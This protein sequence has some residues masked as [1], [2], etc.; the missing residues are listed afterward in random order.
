MKSNQ[1]S[2]SSRTLSIGN[3]EF[4]RAVAVPFSEEVERIGLHY[5]LSPQ[6][7]EAEP[8]AESAVFAAG[9]DL[10]GLVGVF[11]FVGTWAAT[12]AL[13]ELFDIKLG[14]AIRTAIRNA[15]SK[16]SDKTYGITLA[17][18][19][20][21]KRTTILVVAIGASESGLQK[22]EQAVRATLAF[23]AQKAE[24]EPAE[25]VHMYLIEDGKSD[26]IPKITSDLRSALYELRHMKQTTKPV[27]LKRER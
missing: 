15:F 19:N 18:H 12:K 10:S 26:L 5:P 20:A 6:D 22:S 11:T 3:S 8:S 2:V 13:D 24:Q 23:A 21:K 14:P 7:K 1:I 4:I 17:V 25:G 27:V 16:S 9:V